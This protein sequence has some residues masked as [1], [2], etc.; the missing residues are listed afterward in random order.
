MILSRKLA[1]FKNLNESA[2]YRHQLNN[3]VLVN[4]TVIEFKEKRKDEL[5]L[6]KAR[7]TFIIS[8]FTNV[9]R[10]QSGRGIE[11]AT[12]ERMASG[13]PPTC[14][15]IDRSFFIHAPSEHGTQSSV[16]VSLIVHIGLHRCLSR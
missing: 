10:L 14:G 5:H 9:R 13:M 16:F 3:G 2:L 11:G 8:E 4:P 6:R 15:G 1:K 7:E 12:Y